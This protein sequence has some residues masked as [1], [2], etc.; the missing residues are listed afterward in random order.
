MACYRIR[1][2]FTHIILK[3][4]YKEIYFDGTDRMHL[5]TERVRSVGASYDFDAKHLG[6]VTELVFITWATIYFSR[7]LLSHGICYHCKQTK[8]KE[9]C[10]GTFIHVCAW[11]GGGSVCLC[12]P[13]LTEAL[14][15]E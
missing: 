8:K 13:G 2:S 1:I 6:L 3:C 10:Y 14:C 7:R 12:T 11:G 9:I 15:M 4:I 5:V